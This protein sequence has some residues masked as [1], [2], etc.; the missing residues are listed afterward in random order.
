MHVHVHVHARAC[1]CACVVEIEANCM[2]MHVRVRV[3]V[4][5][6]AP[7][8]VQKFARFSKL[9]ALARRLRY[10]EPMLRRLTAMRQATRSSHLLNVL[11]GVED[12]R[13]IV[14]EQGIHQKQA[15]GRDGDG[16]PMDP[17]LGGSRGH[18][19]QH[20]EEEQQ[21]ETATLHA[22]H[23]CENLRRSKQGFGLELARL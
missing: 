12:E 11:A 21:Q 16:E 17:V 5:M 6:R 7:V 23:P 15:E 18:R 3:H 2:C 9:P 20:Q 10:R 1:A 22:H 4:R 19:D 13:T 8:P 14:D